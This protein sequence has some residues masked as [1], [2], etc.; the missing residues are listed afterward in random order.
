MKSFTVQSPGPLLEALFTAWPEVKKKQVRVW[1]KF[2]SVTVNGKPTGQFDHPLKIGDEIALRTERH[3]LPNTKLTI[4]IRILH[5]DHDVIVIDKPAGLLSIA[6][7]RESERTVYSYLMEHVRKNEGSSYRVWIVHRLDQETS[8][9]MILAKSEKVKLALQENWNIVDKKYDA[10]VEGHPDSESGSIKNHL[11]EADPYRV[12]S[13]PESEIT[14]HAITHYRTIKRTAKRTWL[15]LDLI[16]GRRHQIRV[17]L[18]ELG[19]PIVGDKRYGATSNPIKRLAL[20]AK[21]IVFTHPTTQKRMKFELPL[22][23]DL[24]ALLIPT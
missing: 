4:G 19:H 6:S 10:I 24:G 23:G 18:S 16:T 9:V 3:A 17:H 11:D 2:R 22:P 14:R 15:E 7:D 13:A 1:L 21:S 8:G 12:R 20:H 5:E